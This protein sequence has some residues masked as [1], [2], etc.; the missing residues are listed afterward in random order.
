MKWHAL[1]HLTYAYND[2]NYTFTS[3]L[4]NHI[5][6]WKDGIQG[7]HYK[8]LFDFLWYFIVQSFKI[9]LEKEKK[10]EEEWNRYL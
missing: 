10:E 8:K 2:G 4:N 7:P 6:S 3:S 5:S 9:E 1:L